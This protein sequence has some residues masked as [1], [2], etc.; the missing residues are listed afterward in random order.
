[1]N[2]DDLEPSN[3]RWFVHVE[4]D[5]AVGY[6][7]DVRRASSIGCLEVKGGQGRERER[8]GRRWGR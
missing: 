3:L 2:V 8:D 1:M 4:H 5:F 7:S 6:V